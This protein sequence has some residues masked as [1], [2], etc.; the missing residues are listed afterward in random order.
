MNEHDQYMQDF[1]TIFSSLDRWGPGSEEDTLSALHQVP[2]T[3][4]R[5][6]EIGCGNG[7]ATRLLAQH[8]T[9]AIT[10]VDNAA[11]AL[12][13]LTAIARLNGTASRIE[14]VCASMTDLPFADATFDLVW[15]EGCAYIMGVEQA[16]ECWR[17]LLEPNGILVLSDLVWLT[18]T[19]SGEAIEFWRN[20]YPDMTSTE[21]RVEQMD[22][23]GYHLLN[24]F[25]LSRQAW[26][27]Y[28]VPLRARIDELHT[29]MPNS[30][31]L[32]D[33]DR[34]LNIYQDCLGEFGY[35]F[36]ILQKC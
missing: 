21:R 33:L 31:A 22:K 1:M 28:I 18:G 29:H 9:A 27:N 11:S 12:E 16:L 5:L 30:T 13:K 26:D 35:Q 15:A 2:H 10:A 25:S 34:E 23:A 20:D 14:T 17:S 3:P 4:R 36:F 24:T 7:V 6:L 19:P 8:T 32:A